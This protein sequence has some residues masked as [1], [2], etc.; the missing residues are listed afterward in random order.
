VTLLAKVKLV[1][2]GPVTVTNTTA[3]YMMETSGNGDLVVEGFGA[4]ADAFSVVD[5][6][7]ASTGELFSGAVSLKFAALSGDC[8]P[9]FGVW[10][11]VNSVG[12]VT[13]ATGSADLRFNRVAFT[14]TGSTAPVV[15]SGTLTRAHFSD[16]T[17][18]N[19]QTTSSG[20]NAQNAT[21]WTDVSFVRCKFYAS[22]S[23]GRSCIIGSTGTRCAMTRVQLQELYCSPDTV[24]AAQSAVGD[25][26]LHFENAQ[27][28]TLDGLRVEIDHASAVVSPAVVLHCVPKSTE[29]GVFLAR[30]IVVDGGGNTLNL[31]G[32]DGF[33]KLIVDTNVGEATMLLDGLAIYNTLGVASA[34]SSAAKLV[35]VDAEDLNQLIHLR[36]FR[37][38]APIWTPTN[39]S[40]QVVWQNDGHMKMTDCVVDLSATD[41]STEGE[42][43]QGVHLDSGALRTELVG[44]T[45][46]GAQGSDFDNNGTG[47]VL[48]SGCVSLGRADSDTGFARW[49]LGAS[50]GVIVSGC[51]FDYTDMPAGCDVIHCGVAAAGTCIVT[52][53]YIVSGG[54]AITDDA[55][56]LYDASAGCSV[57]NNVGAGRIRC[58]NGGPHHVGFSHTGYT[59]ET[60]YTYTVDEIA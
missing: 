4:G 52:G 28:L 17:F 55:V 48:I 41:A 7:G 19:T 45:V 24:L 59:I 50:V 20:L 54:T 33:V 38:R 58:K 18:N 15:V 39:G 13:L 53:N 29:D 46:T 34:A 9:T 3:D 22:S 10:E 37:Y 2:L 60:N 26:D 16:C 31:Q 32:T 6:G 11:D 49:D 1:C 8:D 36:G 43:I 44:C 42:D 14:L 56:D 40:L 5:G 23:S 51:R 35:Y 21:A 30:N 12:T 27:E 25:F 47:E 57:G